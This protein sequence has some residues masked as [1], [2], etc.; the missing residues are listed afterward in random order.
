M[1]CS[2][3]HMATAAVKGLMKRIN[4]IDELISLRVHFWLTL[5]KPVDIRWQAISINTHVVCVGCDLPVRWPQLVL[6]STLCVFLPAISHASVL[7]QTSN[8]KQ[9]IR[10]LA[11]VH[12]TRS[13]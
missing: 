5:S 10:L 7:V 12:T 8:T 9:H 1:L 6:A 13:S 11:T 3:T 4:K 2:C